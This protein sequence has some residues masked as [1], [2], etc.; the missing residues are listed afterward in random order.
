MIKL[1]I[2]D[3][4]G[5]LINSLNDLSDSMNHALK[6]HGFPTH[7]PEKYRQMVGSGVSVLADRAAG[8]PN[9][10]FTPEVKN[11]ILSDFSEYY[12]AHCIDKTRPYPGIPELL[13]ELDAQGILCAVNSNKPDNF[14]K[15][16]ISA[17]FPDKKFAEI[18]GKREG[19]ER[20]PSPDGANAIMRSLNIPPEEC[21]YIGD[22]NV[23]VQTAR[24]AGISFCGVTWGFRSEQELLSEGAASIAHT[25]EELKEL[26]NT[27]NLKLK[28]E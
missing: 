24:N 8:A 28:N 21:I 3:L 16:I 20:K 11:S 22:S 7:E 17:L 9:E 2:F 13:T 18:W 5:T 25:T 19:Y 10:R 14:T 6:A 26:I 15:Q 12:S 23:D 1:C 27:E 4:D